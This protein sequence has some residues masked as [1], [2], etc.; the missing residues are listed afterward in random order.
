MVRSLRI[1]IA[2]IA[3]W[4]L[5]LFIPFSI[6]P[7]KPGTEPVNLFFGHIYLFLAANLHDQGYSSCWIMIPLL[8]IVVHF[9][10]SFLIAWMLDR[11]F[12]FFR[13]QP[14]AAADE[15]VTIPWYDSEQYSQLL[16]Q[17][18]DRERLDSTYEEWQRRA[19]LLVEELEGRG[20]RIEK[21]LV[22][23]H[24]LVNWC[25]SHS[26]SVDADAR[27]EYARELNR[28]G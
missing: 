2:S 3:V 23:V 1:W 11:V 8:V 16:E 21:V 19:N 24:D 13:L 10:V 25:A 7:S 26:R 9:A 27:S 22:N 15:P 20:T 28:S 6:G 5:L 4:V 12:F 14:T 18:I 17:A